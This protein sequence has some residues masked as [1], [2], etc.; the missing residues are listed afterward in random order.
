[1][2]HAV[3]LVETYL[4]VNGYFTVTEYPVVEAAEDGDYRSATDIDVLAF[5]FPAAGRRLYGSKHPFAPDPELGA[6]PDAAD[7][8]IAEVKEGKAE[9]NP[10]AVEQGV[11]AAALTRFG[12]CTPE[13][14]S[15]LVQ[16]LLRKGQVKTDKGHTVRLLAFGSSRGSGTARHKVILLGHVVR[17][18]ADYIREHWEVLRPAQ[19]KDPV[20]GL[21]VSMEKAGASFDSKRGNKKRSRK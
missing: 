3:A 9:V 11:F 14:S 17:F 7:M 8:I 5:R 1:M 12:C 19:F 6:S 10:G 2:D 20:F 13:R 4:R 16:Q 15:A 21:F 18:L